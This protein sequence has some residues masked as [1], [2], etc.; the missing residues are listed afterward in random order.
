MREFMGQV[1]LQA[2]D[3]A[4]CEVSC[5]ANHHAPGSARIPVSLTL[6]QL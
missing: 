1:S 5:G 3:E 4:D 6:V 2:A